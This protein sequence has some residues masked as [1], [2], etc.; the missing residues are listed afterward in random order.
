MEI[1][2]RKIPAVLLQEVLADAEQKRL[3]PR[4][5]FLGQARDRSAHEKKEADDEHQNGEG[6]FPPARRLRLREAL[7]GAGL[8]GLG[9]RAIP[10]L[11]PDQPLGIESESLPLFG[12]NRGGFYR[13]GSGRV[14]K[15]RRWATAPM[16]SRSGRRESLP[17]GASLG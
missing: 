8:S 1:G 13:R 10:C 7:F 12:A 15:V 4:C 16:A 6:F 3:I 17:R 9:H 11:L 14:E 2:G 5:A